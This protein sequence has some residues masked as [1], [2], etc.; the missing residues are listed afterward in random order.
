M[1]SSP[2]T[3]RGHTWG[4]PSSP[5]FPW[6][7]VAGP[8]RTAIKKA[9]RVLSEA[10]SARPVVTIGPEERGKVDEWTLATVEIPSVHGG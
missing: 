5:Y 7:H 6:R 1:P 10:A 9:E 4:M 3:C 2:C 8:L